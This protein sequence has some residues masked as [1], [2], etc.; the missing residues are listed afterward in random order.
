MRMGK[1][2]VKNIRGMGWKTRIGLIA[3]FTLVFSVLIYQGWNQLRPANAA[4]AVTTNWAILGTGTTSTFPAM[5]LAKGTG[6]NRLLVVKVV[7]D[8]STA[9]TT[10]TPTV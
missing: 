8:Y 7:G 2:I 9:I 6:S 1:I 10:F 4:V 5:T 3:M